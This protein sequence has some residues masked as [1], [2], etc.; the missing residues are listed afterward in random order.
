MAAVIFQQNQFVIT[1]RHQPIGIGQA[2]H[3]HVGFHVVGKRKRFQRGRAALV[4]RRISV[5]GSVELI[6]D[7]DRLRR[8]PEQGHERIKRDDLFLLQSRLGDQIVKLNAEHDFALGAQLGAELLRHRCQ[9]LLFVKRLTEELAQLGVNGFGIIVAQ[10]P[11]TRIDFF[12]EQNA[13]RF[14]ETRQHL[15][16]QRQQVRTLRNAP[17]FAQGAPHQTPALA[18][19]AICERRHFLHRAVKF[20]RDC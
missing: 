7:V 20:F 18:P 5:F 6:N 2:F 19:H 10:K 9:V 16:E 12:L 3:F 4:N 14:R 1:K 11:E 8:H 13:I 17:R 15:N